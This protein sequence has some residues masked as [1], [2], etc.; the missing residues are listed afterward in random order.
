MQPTP[1]W[2]LFP[3][4]LVSFVMQAMI[5]L[6]LSLRL[7]LVASVLMGCRNLSCS[8][9]LGRASLSGVVTHGGRRFLE[10]VSEGLSFRACRSFFS[11][12]ALRM[13]EDCNEYGLVPG[14]RCSS[15]ARSMLYINEEEQADQRTP[16]QKHTSPPQPQRRSEN[17]VRFLQS[18]EFSEGC[19]PLATV[20]CALVGRYGEVR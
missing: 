4:G 1:G 7:S 10:A 16:D 15:Q 19:S 3:E 20:E 13:H 6:G 2:E 5:Y 12:L 8:E 18:A 14:Y 9:C 11:T 17:A